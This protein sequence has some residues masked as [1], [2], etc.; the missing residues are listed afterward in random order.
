MRV[1]NL[2]DIVTKIT[3][4]HLQ[5][6]LTPLKSPDSI[7]SKENIRPSDGCLI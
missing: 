7:M 5:Q 4:C 6:P 1:S 3:Y 2:L